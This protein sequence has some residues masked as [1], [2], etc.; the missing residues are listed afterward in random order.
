MTP[1]LKHLVDALDGLEDL[2]ISDRWQ[3]AQVPGAR[4]LRGGK[5][6]AQDS[7]EGAGVEVYGFGRDELNNIVALCKDGSLRQFFRKNT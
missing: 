3:A 5:I 4:H 2:W 6:P 7:K 1:T